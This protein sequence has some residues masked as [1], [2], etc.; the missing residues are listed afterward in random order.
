MCTQECAA[1]P[2]AATAAAQGLGAGG[3]WAH[4]CSMGEQTSPS[5]SNP[6]QSTS[7]RTVSPCTNIG[8]HACNI[9]QA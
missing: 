4:F 7:C 3:A 6:Q 1:V 5:A 9:N 8:A 2:A